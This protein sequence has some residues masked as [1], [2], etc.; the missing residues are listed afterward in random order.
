MSFFI[1]KSIVFSSFFLVFFKLNKSNKLYNYGDCNYYRG[2]SDWH[3]I[4][5]DDCV[6]YVDGQIQFYATCINDY[7]IQVNTYTI[8]GPNNY[9]NT[10]FNLFFVNKIIT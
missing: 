1:F 5:V 3:A 9:C 4:P 2:F 7:T 6:S 8:A 10:D